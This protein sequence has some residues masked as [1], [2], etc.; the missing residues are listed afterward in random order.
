MV[1]I[2]EITLI[3]L[4]LVH[5]IHS[6]IVGD[7]NDLHL[8]LARNKNAQYLELVDMLAMAQKLLTATRAFQHKSDR[9][10]RQDL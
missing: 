3:I 5:T 9:L 4:N 6:R 7:V 1:K 8:N 10:E 2:K